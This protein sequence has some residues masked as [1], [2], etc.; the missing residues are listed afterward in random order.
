ML[1]FLNLEE[2][3]GRERFLHIR[4]RRCKTL[5]QRRPFSDRPLESVK[6][7]DEAISESFGENLSGKKTECAYQSCTL[8][9][10]VMEVHMSEFVLL[11]FEMIG[12]VAFA[13]SGA[14]TALEKGMDIF[15]VSILGL[16]TAVGGGVIRDLI[17]GITPPMTFQNPVYATI[18]ILTSVI[19][20][21][22]V[23]RYPSFTEKRY[24]E[25]SMLIMD[26]IGLGVFTV[27]GIN[28]AYSLDSDFSMFLLIFVG[29]VT[30]VGGGVMRD[31]MAGNPPYVFIKHFYACASIIGAV[32]CV[33]A[34]SYL[35]DVTSMLLGTAS[36]IVLR[37][38]AAH[39][40]WSLP[41]PR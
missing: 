4:R 31:M 13:A 39:F 28:T 14:M 20:F 18:A 21:F 24:Y 16:T 5:R 12:V 10:C 38:F 19:V 33:F 15:G 35:G 25:I 1:Y 17:L 30:G 8:F 29:V 22:I 36:V 3:N 6:T 40:R 2:E 41:K 27:I 34:W 9:Y 26:S 23:V 7:T 37:L 32:I 11:I